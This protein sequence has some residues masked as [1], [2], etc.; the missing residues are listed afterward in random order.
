MSFL[1]GM[2]A[3][4]ALIAHSKGR[5]EEAY[6]AYTELF[7]KG[8]MESPRYLLPYSI[9]LLRRG[10]YEKAKTVLKKAEK[11]PAACPRTSAASC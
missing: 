5:T 1:S 4:K 9:L 10:E 7:D 3:Q 2:K 11:A 6:A 8:E